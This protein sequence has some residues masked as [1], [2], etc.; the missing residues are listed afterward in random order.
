[1]KYELDMLLCAYLSEYINEELHRG[2]IIDKYTISDAIDAF[3][4]G[5][6]IESTNE[7]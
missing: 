4:G 7:E 3:Y 1:M 6:S 2:A 5:A